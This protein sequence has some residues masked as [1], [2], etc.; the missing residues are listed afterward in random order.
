MKSYIGERILVTGGSGFIGVN[1]IENLLA[2]G[3]NVLNFDIKNPINISHSNIWRNVDLRS[4]E[5]LFVAIKD[6]SPTQIYHLGAKTDLNSDSIIDYSAN[7]DGI[8]NLIDACINAGG[9]K[10]VIFASS[11]LVCKIGYQ[12]TADDDYCPTTAY[13]ESKVIGERIV[14]D[15]EN[16]PFEWVIVRPTS[17]WGPWFDVPY[18]LFFDHVR[19]GRY[20]HPRNMIIRK[21]FGF[22]GN[23]I[24][25][26]KKLMS[27][28]SNLINNNTFYLG[29]YEPIEVLEFSKKIAN[30]FLVREPLSVS[31]WLLSVAAKFGDILVFIGYKNAPLTSFRLKNLKSEMIHDFKELPII[32]GQLPYDINEGINLTINWINNRL[33]S[34][35]ILSTKI[36]QNLKFQKIFVVRA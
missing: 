29:D 27:A 36:Y 4:R 30:K 31:S 17:I 12:P 25:Q 22:V 34:S 33:K 26:L 23:T 6:F 11:R 2:A 28:Q 24:F 7:T 14:R 10:R 9:V 5:N 3:C 18:K 20:I 16:L 8:T 35:I 13:G 15:Y 1:L 32:T 21:S 19:A